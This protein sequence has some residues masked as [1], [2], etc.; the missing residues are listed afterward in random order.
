MFVPSS[1]LNDASSPQLQPPTM[2]QTQSLPF[3]NYNPEIHHNLPTGICSFF[4]LLTR[5]EGRKT[6]AQNRISEKKRK[7]RNY[8]KENKLQKQFRQKIENYFHEYFSNPT[9]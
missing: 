8:N 4:H 7:K 9:C 5:M 6:Q 2:Q 1:P 3:L